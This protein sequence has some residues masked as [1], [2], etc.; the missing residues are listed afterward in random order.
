ML[1]YFLDGG[2]MMVPLTAC[3]I[4]WVAIFIDRTRAFRAAGKGHHDLCKGVQNALGARDVG[5]AITL[6]EQESGPVA[7]T[8]LKG[9]TRYQRLKQLGKPSTEI[10]VSVGR[11][12][13]EYAPKAMQGLERHLGA[14]T[15]MAAIAPLIG[16]VGTVTGMIRAFGVMSD[17]AG[18]EAG[19]VAGGISEAML[20]TAAGLLVAVPCVIVY[21]VFQRRIEDYMSTIETGIA[22]IA[23]FIGEA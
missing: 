22:D 20:T 4:L 16:M 15:L 9:L 12:M 14:L 8:F 18:L 17:Q 1:G 2:W 13:E 19:A 6:C 23:E 10:E 7:A 5:K 21:Y 11:T 3:S